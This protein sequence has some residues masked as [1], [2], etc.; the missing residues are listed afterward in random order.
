MGIARGDLVG[1][2][3]RRAGVLGFAGGRSMWT[4]RRVLSFI[5]LDSSH[6]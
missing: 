1:H 3:A 5:C 2:G 4:A 6:I